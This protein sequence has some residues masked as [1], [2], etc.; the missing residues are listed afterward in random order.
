MTDVR[1]YNSINKEFTWLIVWKNWDELKR[2]EV[3][4]AY[5]RGF[6]GQNIL[7]EKNI[8]YQVLWYRN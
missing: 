5:V 3:L 2:S 7:K 1:N 4:L 6:I 8:D